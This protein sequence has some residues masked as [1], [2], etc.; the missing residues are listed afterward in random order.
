[1]KDLTDTICR[2]RNKSCTLRKEL[3]L[4]IAEFMR[5]HGVRDEKGTLSFTID[6]DVHEEFDPV[7]LCVETD[8]HTGDMG[9]ETMDAIHLNGEDLS[10][11]TS[12]YC[13]TAN[14]LDLFDLMEIYEYLDYIEKEEYDDLEFGYGRLKVKEE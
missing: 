12:S 8:R 6:S 1:M 13:S 4:A 9:M 14:E 10:F 3:L 11:E 7:W 5:D 2:F